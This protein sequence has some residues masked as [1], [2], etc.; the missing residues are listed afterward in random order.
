[1]ARNKKNSVGITLDAD[2]TGFTKGVNEAQSKLESFGKQAGGMASGPLNSFAGGVGRLASPIGAA[3]VAVGGLVAV[4]DNLSS[5]SAKAF[6]VFQSASLSQMS[7]KQV[8]QMAKMYQEVGLTMEQIADQQKDI[9]DRLGDALTN[10]AGSMF[11]DVIQPLK[12]NIFELQ[13]MADAGEDVYAKIYFAAKAQG[14]STSQIVNMFETMGNDATKRLTV[15]KDFNSEQEY[16]NKLGKQVVE[17]TDEQS[18]AFRRY[19][20]ETDEMASA[21]EKWKNNQLAPIAASL[22]GI[23]KTINEINAIQPDTPNLLNVPGKAENVRDSHRRRIIDAKI[24]SGKTLSADDQAFY[25]ANMNPNKKT[26]KP[27]AAK[28]VIPVGSSQE[29][30]NKGLLQFQSEKQKI[31]NETALAK[32]QYEQLKSEIGKSLDTAYGGDKSKQAEAY[33]QLDEGYKER[34]EQINKSATTATNK[35]NKDAESAARKAEAAAKKHNDELLKAQEKWEKSMSELASST[36]DY[37]IKQHDRQMAELKKSIRESGKALGKSVDEINAKVKEAEATANRIR[38]EMY[39]SAIGYEDP[40]KD[41]KDVTGA[42]GDFGSLNQDQSTFLQNAQDDRLGF[43]AN[44]FMVDKTEQL[45][46]EL[47][48]RKKLELELNDALV[49]STEERVKRQAAIEAQF[50]TAEMALMQQ[51]T[52]AKLTM[53]GGMAGD[54]GSILSGVLGESNAA[55]KAAF[56]VQKGIAMAQIM[57][58][59]QVALSQALATP[60]PASIAAYAQI[61]SMGAQLVSTAKGTNIQGQAHSGIEEVP[62]SLGKDSTWILQA[63][64]RVVSRGQNKQ[65]QQFL[66]N[67]DSSSTGG[68]DITVNAPLIVQGDVSGD[69]KKFQE[70]LKKHS[71][72]VNQAVRDAQKRTS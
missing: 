61:L 34:L 72:S 57:M 24:N 71:Q 16:Q 23:L 69:D 68:G 39:N 58:N 2:T 42:I 25:D 11:T 52:Q 45:R 17:L 56:A 9:K 12:L 49:Q 20:K 18:D 64:E 21:W 37:R 60:F 41:L 50:N 10:Q 35:R 14:L 54:V 6:E 44:P 36:A 51:N 27:E 15:L 53:I 32:S 59:M 31:I 7:I 26:T 8:Q 66:D 28:P 48:Q 4:M 5:A 29:V 40:N 67:Q 63:G 38:G 46:Q 47:E 33:K 30:L 3:T 19:K 70:M 22:A 43:S 13:K 65:L 55:S 62:G 1:M